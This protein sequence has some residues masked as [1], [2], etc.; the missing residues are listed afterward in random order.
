[1]RMPVSQI[2][3]LIACLC[4]AKAT[5]AE[6]P[7]LILIMADDLGY[8]TIGVNGGTSYSTPVLD[9][10]AEQG[11]RFT[12]CFVQPLCT[13]T[14]CQIMTGRYNIRNYIDFGVL[15]ADEVTFGKLLQQ[16]G[17]HTCIVGKWQLGHDPELPQIFGFDESCLWQH[18][19][20]PPRYANPGLE[21]NG[22]EKD[23]SDGEYGPDLVAD[24]ALDFITRHQTEPF[25]VY[26]PMI[27]THSPYPPTPAS[28]NWNPAAKTDK[29]GSDV[30]QFG[31]MVK[32][33]D[34]IIGRFVS[35]LEKLNLRDNTMIVFLGDNGTGRGVHSIMDNRVVVGAKGATTTFGM[36]VPLIVSW[37]NRVQSR[38]CDDLIDSTDF[39][40]TFLEA[41]GVRAPENSVLDGVSFLPQLVG[42]EGQARSWIYSWYFPRT[43]QKGKLR[44][45]A[46]NQKYKL[47]RTGEFFDIEADP[48]ETTPLELSKAPC[49]AHEK[50]ELQ[51]VLDSFR[52]SRPTELAIGR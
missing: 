14:R 39:L 6:R 45:F 9:Q 31:G 33:M 24:Y 22:V 27:L 17:Y 46:F 51:L 34:A 11:V 13:P 50:Q 7:N 15:K 42:E 30:R 47:Y 43:R 52:N 16:A 38:V 20:R 19:R 23:Y 8:E 5:A 25:F 41:T 21:I 26:Y 2:F 4:M 3:A 35:H 49:L 37:P 29:E 12:N 40:P 44:E 48:H 18:T 28:D 32:Y 36:H 1:M 10:L